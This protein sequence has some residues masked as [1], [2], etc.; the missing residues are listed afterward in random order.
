MTTQTEGLPESHF[1]QL[2]SALLPSPARLHTIWEADPIR[3]EDHQGSAS[4]QTTQ[5]DRSSEETEDDWSAT[6]LNCRTETTP[7]LGTNYHRRYAK[8]Q[9]RLQYEKI[10]QSKNATFLAKR[11][12]DRDRG[13]WPSNTQNRAPKL[14]G[15]SHQFKRNRVPNSARSAQLHSTGSP[16]SNPAGHPQN[17]LRIRIKFD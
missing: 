2:P 10:G 9:S 3:S 13:S 1:R 5:T 6:H 12:R 16:K 8:H 11:L 17:N 7:Y 14:I 4:I 15:Y